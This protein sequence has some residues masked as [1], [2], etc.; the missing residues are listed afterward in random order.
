M[1]EKNINEISD[2]ILKD[3]KVNKK[4][5]YPRVKKKKAI[6]TCCYTGIGSAIQIQDIL[7]N[8]LNQTENEFTIIPYDYKRLSEN[9][10]REL[11]FQVYDVIAIIGTE[12]PKVN[13]IT[14]IGLD[15]LIVGQDI[16]KFISLIKKYLDIDEE[17]L[18][19]DLV[20]NFSTQKIIENLT[21]LDA[22]KILKSVEKAADKME[23]KLKVKLSHSRRF[24]L[25][26]HSCCMVERILRKEKVDDQLDID[27][28]LAK[29]RLRVD[30]IKYSL[31]DIEKEYSIDVSELE[32]RLIYDIIF[33]E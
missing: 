9:K 30:I 19:K 26:L 29:E 12:D 2:E 10:Q 25:Y 3:V 24:L 32:I 23:E 28:F 33:G 8:S 6:L 13:G 1:Q 4:I 27:E 31:K 15:K 14:Y 11:P 16:N 18:K 21:I 17:Q 5:I 7:Q 22:E 20:F